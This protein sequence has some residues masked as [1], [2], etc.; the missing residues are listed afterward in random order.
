MPDTKTNLVILEKLAA[1]IGASKIGYDNTSSGLSA[2]DLQAAIDE[3]KGL[4]VAEPSNLCSG[5]YTGDGN[6]NRTIVHG[7][8][9]IGGI[10]ILP[11]TDTSYGQLYWH[12]DALTYVK[13][14][15][16]LVLQTATV[17]PGGVTTF[18]AIEETSFRVGSAGSVNDNTVDYVYLASRI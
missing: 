6:D 13:T 5:T 15:V 2:T 16:T 4:I 17:P 10:H 11:I 1:I 8:N 14:N 18:G 12:R 3:V 7:C 9:L